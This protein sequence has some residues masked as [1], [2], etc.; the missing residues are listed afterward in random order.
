MSSVSGIH[1]LFYDGKSADARQ[2]KLL[3][4][5]DHI[6]LTG[7]SETLAWA[8]NDLAVDWHA[9]FD[10]RLRHKDFPDAV[11]VIQEEKRA[12][13]DGKVSGKLVYVHDKCFYLMQIC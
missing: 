9:K 10:V 13:C 6:L 4:N 1:G 8:I 2:V 12:A 7:P 11:L 3:L 5:P